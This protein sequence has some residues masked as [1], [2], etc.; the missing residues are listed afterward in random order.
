MSSALDNSISGNPYHKSMCD[1]D[2]DCDC[3]CV[4]VL[5]QSE[6][7][8]LHHISSKLYFKFYRVT[9][10]NYDSK[11]NYWVKERLTEIKYKKKYK[12]FLAK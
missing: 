1:C 12:L 11:T 6:C 3:D 10:N 2:C 9:W 4:L 8:C 7:Q 5:S